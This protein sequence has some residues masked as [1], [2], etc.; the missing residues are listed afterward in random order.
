MR[1]RP[2]LV[3]VAL[4]ATAAATLG[5]AGTPA[6]AMSALPASECAGKTAWPE[7]VNTDAN[8][9]KGTIEKENPNVKAT[10]V[11]QGASVTTDLRCD[12]VRVF[13]TPERK[14]SETPKVG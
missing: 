13:A 6:T 7:L 10:V 5:V 3:S 2:V 4:V 14:V 9:A 12:R 8:Q 1:I 11:E